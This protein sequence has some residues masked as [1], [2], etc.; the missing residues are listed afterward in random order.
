MLLTGP[1]TTVRW[2]LKH[3]LIRHGVR[4]AA[5]AGDPVAAL[6]T[7]P[8]ARA[9]PYPLY[10]QLRER[11]PL[12]AGP[13]VCTTARHDV[14]T[15]LLRDDRFGVGFTGVQLPLGAVA[16]T[17]LAE[18]R[19]PIGPVDPPSLLAVDPPLHS[20]LRRVVARVFT[21]RAVEAQRPRIEERCAELLDDLA[22]RGGDEPVDLVARYAALLPV[23]V[24]AEILGVPLA[25]RGRFLRWGAPAPD[26]RLRTE[27]AG[28]PACRVRCARP[29]RV[30]ARPLRAAARRARRRPVQPARAA[31]RR[32]PAHR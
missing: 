23:T 25:M 1:A 8:A 16:L 12:L 18:W 14:A 17:R 24:I 27:P 11:A 5:R 30:A 7:D 32:R 19:A 10:R 31:R 21:A 4:R 9:D 2:A 26:P 22:A 28:V 20:R 13:L 29:Q 6:Q 3:G 15:M